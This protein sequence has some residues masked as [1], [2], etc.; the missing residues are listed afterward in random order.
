ML[1]LSKYTEIVNN[2]LYNSTH[3]SGRKDEAPA[4]SI[5]FRQEERRL[6]SFLRLLD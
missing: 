5:S 3:F 6:L 1:D 2:T 4:L